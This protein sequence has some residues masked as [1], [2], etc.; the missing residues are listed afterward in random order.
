MQTKIRQLIS[1][2]K[3]QIKIPGDVID[4]LSDIFFSALGSDFFSNVHMMKNRYTL[5]KEPAHPLIKNL[6]NKNLKAIAVIELIEIGLYLKCFMHDPEISACIDS[7]KNRTQYSSTLFQLAVAFRI[8]KPGCDVQLEPKTLTGK[9]DIKFRYNENDFIGE[10]YRPSFNFFTWFGEAISV[11]CNGLITSVP[12]NKK[13]AFTV[14]LNSVLSFDGARRF[15]SV[16]SKEI[17]QFESSSE[18]KK[19][20]C[21]NSHI[22]GIEDITELKNDPD[23]LSYETGKVEQIRYDDC[24]SSV[25]ERKV[26]M[27]K[28]LGGKDTRRLEGDRGSRVFIWKNFE[29]RLTKNSYQR[30]EKKISKKLKQTKTDHASNKRM[31]F[32][33]MPFGVYTENDFESYHNSISKRVIPKHDNVFGIFLFDRQLGNNRYAYQGILLHKWGF[34]DLAK[35]LL[36]KMNQVEESDIFSL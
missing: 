35:S 14:K 34:H 13:Y 6:L 21:L 15:L 22:I 9:A 10:C 32:V 3:K 26:E 28:L 17:S 8:K 20:L 36:L 1:E 16:M 31:L 29:Q 25:V 19:E 24:D 11:I 27:S 12:K 23:F 18:N 5:R 7:L 2:S 4:E 33:E 30:L